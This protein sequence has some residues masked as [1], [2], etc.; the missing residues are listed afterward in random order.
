MT[1]H[2]FQ[3]MS[4]QNMNEEIKNKK[5]I[6]LMT[7]HHVENYG[8]AYQA[9]ALARSIEN[10]GFD[11]ELIDYRRK[12]DAPLMQL[13]VLS[14]IKTLV[15][16]QKNNYTRIYSKDCIK[17][18]FDMFYSNNFKYTSRCISNQDFNKLNSEFDG[19]VCGS[20]QIW[21]PDWFD[22][23][24]FLKFVVD[25]RRK[26]AY[27]PSFGVKRI[28]DE[29]IAFQIK[30]CLDEFVN[31]SARESSACTLITE[32]IGRKDVPCVLDPVFLLETDTWNDIMVAEESNIEYALI[33]FLKNNDEYF[34]YAVNLAKKKNLEVK[35]MHSTQS[36]DNIFANM[37]NPA[38]EKF[39]GEIRNASF[40]FTDS[41]HVTA[42]AI[43]F[44]IQFL[45]FNKTKDLCEKDRNC[46][47]VD[48][49]DCLGINNH[50]YDSSIDFC[51]NTI[52]YLFVK[53]KLSKLKVES[54]NYLQKA[55]SSLPQKE[56]FLG[57]DCDRQME[58]CSAE[59]SEALRYRIGRNNSILIKRI[60]DL[61]LSLN[62]KCYGCKYSDAPD[63]KPIFYY[64][65]QNELIQGKSLL[66]IYLR[67]YI[68]YDMLKIRKK[69][70]NGLKTF[71]T[72]FRF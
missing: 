58:G 54:L 39:L 68:V 46:R 22:N 71:I 19:F 31:L 7:W 36:E 16:P 34:Q 3:G 37:D 26:I 61:K 5:K 60:I 66:S 15:H 69:F 67:Y 52:D 13:S 49:F 56:P 11:V 4:V 32:L 9:Y 42:L 51:D 44:E 50:I 59:P 70:S 29:D 25:K 2:G 23:R 24:Y 20:D 21:G 10:L 62:E 47:I 38:P 28:Y 6:G 48:L 64:R 41:F 65:L 63:R 27:A 12:S 8:T 57:D 55:L 33:Y 72:N 43:I 17:P 40:V 53:K 14:L 18:L 45:T 35:I 30:E 1:K